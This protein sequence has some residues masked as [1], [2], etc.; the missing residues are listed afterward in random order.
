MWPS[1]TLMRI[2]IDG[3]LERGGAGAAVGVEEALAILAFAQVDLDQLLDGVGDL[4][5]RQGGT[6]DMAQARVLFAGAAQRELVEL[7]ALLIDA[8]DADVAH[9]VVAAG[10]DAAADLDLQL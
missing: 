2:G 3:L 6:E 9:M 1:W 5:G 10:V 7:L 4:V 8:Q